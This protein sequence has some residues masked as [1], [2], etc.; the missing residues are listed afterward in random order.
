MNTKDGSVFKINIT[1]DFFIHVHVHIGRVHFIG[2]ELRSWD[3]SRMNSGYKEPKPDVFKLKSR[4]LRH[5]K[6]CLKSDF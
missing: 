3:N 2:M 4:I 6:N 5:F 1:P